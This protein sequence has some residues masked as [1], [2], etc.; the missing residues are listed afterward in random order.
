VDERFCLSRADARGLVSFFLYSG[1]MPLH[2]YAVSC[3]Q[4]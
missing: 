2:R 1:T 3:R 4:V